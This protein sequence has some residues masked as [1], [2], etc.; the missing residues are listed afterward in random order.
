MCQKKWT[1]MRSLAV[2]CPIAVIMAAIQTALILSLRIAKYRHI[3]WPMTLMAVLSATYL[4]AG[5][6]CHYWDI[7]KHR[8]VRGISFIFVFIDALGDV[9]SL[10]SVFFQP[11]L[12]VA[13][14]IIYATEFTLWCGIFACGGY[15]N[16]RPWLMRKLEKHRSRAVSTPSSSEVSHAEEANSAS[17]CIATHDLPSSTSVF[18]TPSGELSTVRARTNP[19]LSLTERSG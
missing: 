2:V 1:I 19:S 5:V 12:D 11:K 14:M 16:L 6:L 7:W 8:T 3:H 4:A 18:R 9:F 15:F 17:P 10:V 13:G